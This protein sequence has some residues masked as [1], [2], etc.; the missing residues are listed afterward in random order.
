MKNLM[1]GLVCFACC[2]LASAHAQVDAS[3]NKIPE[4]NPKTMTVLMIETA[5]D[6]PLVKNIVTKPT[7]VVSNRVWVRC[8]H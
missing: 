5:N 2:S 8:T 1:I 6:K 7:C 4:L 3:L